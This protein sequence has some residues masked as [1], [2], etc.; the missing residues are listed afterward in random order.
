MD[1]TARGQQTLLAWHQLAPRYGLPDKLE[2]DLNPFTGTLRSLPATLNVPIFLPKVGAAPT[3][4]EE[5]T[6]ESLRRFIAEWRPLIGAD[7]A[8]LSLV[9]RTDEPNG[10]RLA[11]YEQRPF[12]Y[13]LRGGYGTLVIHFGTD[14]RLLDLSSNCL[15]NTER[16]Q[17][18]T[19]GMVPKL[20]WEDAASRIK[21]RAITVT[22]ASGRQQNF[23]LPMNDSASVRQLVFYVLPSKSQSDALELHLAWE[24]DLP[25][26]PVRTIYLDAFDDQVIASS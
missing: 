16:L 10:I 20:T 8:L 17:A 14:R 22:D 6:R 25:N 19:N 12:R 18:V 9:E 4:I 3:Q 24:I 11:R 7:P 23:T 21:G 15:P 5:E 26:A 1:Q 13:P 2:P